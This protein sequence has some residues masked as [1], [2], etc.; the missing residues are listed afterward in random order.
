MGTQSIPML[1][2]AAFYAAGDPISTAILQDK[3]SLSD[4]DVKEGITLLQD[5]L[6]QHTPFCLQ[7]VGEKFFLR[8]RSE[9]GDCINSII[10]QPKK[11]RLSDA[12]IETLAII[13]YKQPITKADIETVRGVDCESVIGSLTSEG[14]IRQIG[15]L[16]RPGSPTLYQTTEKFLIVFN[17]KGVND[18]PCLTNFQD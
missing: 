18:L 15:N 3:L 2:F 10:K 4:I 11:Q 9:Y 16:L 17:L 6:L 13:A 12:A 5:I 7:E 1:L 14:L 8:T